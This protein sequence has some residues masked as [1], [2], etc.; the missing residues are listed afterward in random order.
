MSIFVLTALFLSLI[1]NVNSKQMNET[2][3]GIY[4]GHITQWSDYPYIASIR[5]NDEDTHCCAGTIISLNPPVLL[6]AAHCIHPNRE[7]QCN[8]KVII[9]CDH[10][11]CA[12]DQATTYEIKDTVIHPQFTHSFFY[13]QPP[14]FDIALIRLS[15]VIDAPIGVQ[16]I[17][18][19]PGDPC[20]MNL[21]PLTVIGY[22]KTRT[23]SI[24]TNLRYAGSD[25]V[26]ASMC[27]SEAGVDFP[28]NYY[29]WPSI[30]CFM[31]YFNMDVVACGG[32]DGG[33]VVNAGAGGG[34]L[35]G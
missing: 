21:N 16:N 34:Q 17:T 24:P 28:E 15:S 27:N 6:T 19:D 32:D 9:G 22:G 5:H 23:V 13:T 11:S 1:L 29:D 3:L 18:I 12:E 4:D 2:G 14:Q 26:R 10:V 30:L 25:W 33:P 35:V 7:M 31:D 8:Q 20:C